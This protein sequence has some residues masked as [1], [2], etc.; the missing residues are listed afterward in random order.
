[1]SGRCLLR[2]LLQQRH[3]LAPTDQRHD[4][5]P[6]RCGKAALADALPDD[7]TNQNWHGNAF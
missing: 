2:A 3:F 6:V 1:M 4:R 7:F 5:H